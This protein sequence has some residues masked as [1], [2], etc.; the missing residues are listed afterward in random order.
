MVKSTASMPVGCIYGET[1]SIIS[2]TNAVQRSNTAVAVE[3]EGCS[4]RG[5]ASH[6]GGMVLGMHECWF[7]EGGSTHVYYDAN[8]L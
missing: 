8:S 4:P 1:L 6:E 7:G 3:C 5:R 2:S